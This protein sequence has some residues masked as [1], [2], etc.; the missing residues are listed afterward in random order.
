MLGVFS[1]EKCF[2]YWQVN[3]MERIREAIELA[4][5]KGLGVGGPERGNRRLLPLQSAENTFDAQHMP[6]HA[7]DEKHL[8]KT[9]IVAHRASNPMTPAFD[10]LRTSVLQLMEANNWQ[11]LAITSPT[12]GCGKTVT[13]INLALSIARIPN[14]HV[15]LLDLDMRRPLI[16]SYLGFKPKG[17][18]FEILNGEMAE[19]MCMTRI[20]VAGSRLTIIPNRVA[21]ANPAEVISSR[22]M[23]GFLERLCSGPGN[24]VIVMDTPPMLVCDDVLALLPMIDCVTLSVAEKMS[25]PQEVF[26]CERHLKAVNYLGLV[27][28]KSHELQ[29]HTYY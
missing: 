5:S 6:V 13:A 14:R 1:S 21:V 25:K 26:A 23:S 12:P 2:W 24:P 7:V 15:V 20:D 3:G 8:E 16:A 9:R 17:G 28:T 10:I 22:E 19:E 18:L 4:K 29:E 11:T 27:L